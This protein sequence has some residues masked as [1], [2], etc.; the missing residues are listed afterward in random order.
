[1]D[2]MPP[3]RDQRR[4]VEH[5]VRGEVGVG[6]E[7]GELMVNVVDPPAAVAVHPSPEDRPWDEDMGLV[8]ERTAI[9]A[10]VEVILRFPDHGFLTR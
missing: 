7:P 6:E 8:D 10:E 2:F 9:P 3:V 4:V 1:M 5:V